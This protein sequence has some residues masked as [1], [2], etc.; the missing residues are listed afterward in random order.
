MVT[1]LLFRHYSLC[2]STVATLLLATQSGTATAEEPAGADAPLLE[3]VEV[4]VTPQSERSHSVTI[5]TEEQMRRQHMQ[6]MNDVLFF[7]VPG[8][9]TARRSNLGFM[10]P[11]SGFRI[12]GLKRE[13]VAVFVDGIPSQVN[14][15]FHPLVD[16]YTPDLIERLEITRGGSSVLHGAS[17][18]GG[19]ID[20]YTPTPGPGLGG[21]AKLIGGRYDTREVQARVGYGG[22]NGTVQL[23]VT[24]RTTEGYRPNQEF[25]ATTFNFK[26]TYELNPTWEMGF[27][28]GQTRADI[29][30]PG[31]VSFPS[32]SKSTQDPTNV[33]LTLD[34]RTADS[35]S[36]IA[37]YWNQAE[38]E[39][40]RNG[41]GV[42]TGFKR[43]DESEYGL[44][45]KHD[46]LMGLSKTYTAGLDVVNYDDKRTPGGGPDAGVV[47]EKNS[48][49]F[50]SP[51]A[52][53]SHPFGNNVVDGGLRYTY[54]DQ[55]G[56]D[57]SPELGLVHHVDQSLALR[58]RG[59][60]SFRVPRVN[61]AD[62]PFGI[63]NPDLEPEDFWEIEAGVNKTFLGN[64]A[65]V[66]AVVWYRDG[67]NLITTVGMGGSAQSVNTGEFRHKGFETTLDVAINANW[68]VSMAGTLQDIED[69]IEVPEKILDLGVNFDQGPFG[70]S[71]L[72]RYAA[73][74]LGNARTGEE[75]DN[76]FVADLHLSWR[77]HKHVELSVDI[78]NITDEDYE[79]VLGYPQVPRAAFF[80]IR[81]DI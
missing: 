44:R 9:N 12:R 69:E 34:R 43:F 46:W 35:S 24:D 60:H 8:V 30:N 59:G 33:A 6:N 16:Q 72:T 80:G 58:A 68:S 52:H 37:L 62:A 29:E 2:L 14:N 21:Y 25:D 77:V 36:F 81:G 42:K 11:N 78:D 65:V 73:D 20:I 71:L 18:V 64:R 31:S 45:L 49:T 32:L 23:G 47:Y 3:P 76:Y 57:W 79:T 17:A 50:Y 10:G 61:D 40:I 70:A 4:S 39:S 26:A 7:G 75:L 54:S 74:A 41:M 56:S 48:E 63:P 5:I 13:R 1:R 53:A 38:V 15:H 28:Y 19:V 22:E 51:Y 55:F 67:D 27:R 66:D